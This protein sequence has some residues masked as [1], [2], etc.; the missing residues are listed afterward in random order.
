MITGFPD[1]Q[2]KNCTIDGHESVAE[3]FSPAQAIVLNP[4]ISSASPCKYVAE[5][6]I[7]SES[8]TLKPSRTRE[9]CTLNLLFAVCSTRAGDLKSPGKPGRNLERESE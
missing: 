6:L 1:L 7:W 3:S 4:R 2:E 5:G 8:P 9:T